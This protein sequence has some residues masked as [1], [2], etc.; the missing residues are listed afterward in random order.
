MTYS[1]QPLISFTQTICPRYTAGGTTV[2]LSVRENPAERDQSYYYYWST[3]TTTRDLGHCFDN[4][5]ETYK[6]LQNPE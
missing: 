2:I 1:K 3:S 5:C 4:F 6:L